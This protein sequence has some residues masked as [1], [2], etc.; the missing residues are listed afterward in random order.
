MSDND[1]KTVSA[2]TGQFPA[3]SVAQ[4]TQGGSNPPEGGKSVPVVS[5]T[6]PD[7]ERLVEKLNI[8][9]LQVGRDLRFEVDLNS[10][11]AVIQ[12]LDSETGEVIRQIPPEKAELYLSEGGDMALRLMDA[13]V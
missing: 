3:L 6:K 8:A 13:S 4:R 12:V 1:V 2:T 9:S 7:L 11:R 10:R 5:A